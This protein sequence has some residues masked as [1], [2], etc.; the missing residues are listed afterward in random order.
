M[1]KALST[2][3]LND[4]KF[5]KLGNIKKILSDKEMLEKL[6]ET[7]RQKWKAQFTWEKISDQYERLFFQLMKR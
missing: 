1:R 6:G 4:S 2:I 3:D 5:Q 7:G